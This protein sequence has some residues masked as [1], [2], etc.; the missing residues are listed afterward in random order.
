MVALCKAM[1]SMVKPGPNPYKTPHLSP[2]P[3]VP[4]PS[5]MDHLLISSS[6]NRTHALDMFP[7]SLRTCLVALSLSSFNP[8]VASIRFK[9]AGPPGWATQNNEF[10]SLIPSGW[11][12]SSRL[13]SM[14]KVSPT[15]RKCPSIAPSEL[16]KIVSE[17][18]TRIGS[19]DHGRSTVTKE[20]LAHQR[21]QVSFGGSTKRDDCDLGTHDENARSGVVLG[22][23]FG[24]TE[25]GG[26]GEAT[27]VV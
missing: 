23:V 21:V 24:E 10:Q 3:V 18:E 16:G 14:W 12:I 5:S 13:F 11:N 7:Y 25:H 4:F 27:L 17:A 6:I 9:I 19:N 22:E 26:A 20:C 1:V 15:S 8:T 2:S